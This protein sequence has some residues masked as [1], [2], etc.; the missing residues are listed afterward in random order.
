[1]IVYQSVLIHSIHSL[2]GGDQEIT[3]YCGDSLT[4]AIYSLQEGLDQI[5][6][7]R[8]LIIELWAKKIIAWEYGSIKDVKYLYRDKSYIDYHN[9]NKGEQNE[10]G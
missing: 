8:G 4:E 9:C 1:M 6:K 3:V 2:K 5:K 10:Q 7:E